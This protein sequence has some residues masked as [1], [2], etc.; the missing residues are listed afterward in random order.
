MRKL[1]LIAPLCLLMACGSLWEYRELHELKQFVWNK[2]DV[3]TYTADISET[4]KYDVFV[5]FRHVQGFPYKEVGVNMQMKADGVDESQTF[6]I[7]VI[8]DGK[9][10]LGEGSV[11]IWDI[12]HPA[13]KGIELQ[14][15]GCEFALE[16][17]MNREDLQLVME[18]GV[19]IKKT[20]LAK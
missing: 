14:K 15:G 19:M 9:E 18:V 16:H 3:Q 4:G 10:Y 7:P 2:S 6:V 1:I 17:Q 11:D 5:L 20:E 13:Y 8:G 12:E